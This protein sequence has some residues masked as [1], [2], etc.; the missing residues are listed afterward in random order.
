MSLNDLREGDRVVVEL[1]P[2]FAKGAIDGCYEITD[3]LPGGWQP[4]V[5]DA[6]SYMDYGFGWYPYSFGNGSVS[7]ITC[8]SEENNNRVIQY[9]ARVVSR[10]S[11]TAEGALIQHTR[12]PS[13]SSVS[14]DQEITIK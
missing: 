6:Y 11:Y 1:R 7:F 5:R 8:G 9:S 2:T 12:F 3:N 10:G 13:I 14:S 4:M